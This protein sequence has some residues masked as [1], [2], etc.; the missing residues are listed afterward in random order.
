LALA[1]FEL[2]CEHPVSLEGLSDHLL[3]LRAILGEGERSERSI[4]RRLA[5]LC[6]EP[7]DQRAVRDRVEQAFRLEQLVMRGNADAAYMAAIGVEAPEL[8]VR[9]LEEN[10]RALLRDMV[11]GHI[12]ANVKGIADDLLPPDET[13]ESREVE[14]PPEPAFVVRRGREAT[15]D[16]LLGLDDAPGLF[17]QTEHPPARRIAEE[18]PTEEHAAVP[19]AGDAAASTD[20]ED[21]G[22]DD[23]ASDY[24]A[25][26]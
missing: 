3:A 16:T 9:E 15:T 21:W 13:G 2:G 11:C 18:A 25:A 10:L 1:R 6:A 8:V 4:S 22:L 23:D 17:V 19:A 24:S 7:A 12:D 14:N 20:S 5:A 26:V